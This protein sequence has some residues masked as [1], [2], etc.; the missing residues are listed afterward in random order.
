MFIV[1]E[2]KNQAKFGEKWDVISQ[3]EKC[4]QTI[5]LWRNVRFADSSVRTICD[6]ADRITESAKSDTMDVGPIY[7]YCCRY[8]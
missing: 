4:A 5:G 6:N 2:V 3:I 8:K 7:F 1:I